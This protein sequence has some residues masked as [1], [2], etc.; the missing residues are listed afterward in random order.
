MRLIP[1]S[2]GLAQDPNY[3]SC[4]EFLNSGLSVE[5][6]QRR[7]GIDISQV[8]NLQQKAIDAGDF[9]PEDLRQKLHGMLSD[10]DTQVSAMF[11]PNKIAE[12]FQRTVRCFP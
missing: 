9:W 10:I 5:Q 1:S 7:L 11:D 6:I 12:E 2:N 4:T 8:K 3:V